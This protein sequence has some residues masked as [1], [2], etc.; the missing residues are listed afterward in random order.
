MHAPL[1]C[2]FLLHFFSNICDNFLCCN[3]YY[4]ICKAI[5]CTESSLFSHIHNFWLFFFQQ[6]RFF[7]FFQKKF[8][9]YETSHCSVITWLL[10]TSS[11]GQKIIE[12]WY[13]Y[14]F[15]DFST[16]DACLRGNCVNNV[17]D[18]N[19]LLLRFS[20][21]R[22]FHP[23]LSPIVAILFSIEKILLQTLSNNFLSITLNFLDT[24]SYFS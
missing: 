1:N 18:F 6:D 2:I 11:W 14:H 9:L 23:F 12:N 3:N 20:S 10:S 22:F 13:F 16:V 15:L 7:K 8:V 4:V 5:W 24:N 19:F 21:L 17:T